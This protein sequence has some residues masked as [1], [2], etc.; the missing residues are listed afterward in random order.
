[1]DINKCDLL[2][3]CCLGIDHQLALD[4]QVNQIIED[5]ICMLMLINVKS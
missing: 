2:E 1:M 3:I 4:N 5:R